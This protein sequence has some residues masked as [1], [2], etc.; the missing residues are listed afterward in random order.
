MKIIQF[1]QIVKLICTICRKSKSLFVSLK[2]CVFQCRNNIYIYIYIY[3][4]CIYNKISYVCHIPSIT[5]LFPNIE[6][7]LLFKMLPNINWFVNLLLKNW[8]MLRTFQMPLV[9]S[10]LREIWYIRFTVDE[11]KVNWLGRFGV[12]WYC[13]FLTES[14]SNEWQPYLPI[15]YTVI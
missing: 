2:I 11:L 1:S 3:I 7:I 15:Q 6:Q 4:L 8:N 10:S 12:T 5:N 9:I 13:W 14:E